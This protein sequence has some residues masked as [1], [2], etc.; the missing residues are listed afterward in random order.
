MTMHTFFETAQG[1]YITVIISYPVKGQVFTMVQGWGEGKPS[2]GFPF[3][4][5]QRNIL[6]YYRNISHRSE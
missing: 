5:G 3:F 4:Q 2:P 6:T 1:R